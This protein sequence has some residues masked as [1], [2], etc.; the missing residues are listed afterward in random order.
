MFGV[1][2]DESHQFCFISLLQIKAHHEQIIKTCLQLLTESD[3]LF[4]LLCKL[5]IFIL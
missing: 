5:L 3:K 1:A 2:L 4:V